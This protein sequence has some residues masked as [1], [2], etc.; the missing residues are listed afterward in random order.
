ME[1]IRVREK[2]FQTFTKPSVALGNFDGVHLG[3]QEILKRTVDTAHRKGR[4]AVVYTFDPH[5][6]LVLNQ[7]PEIPQITTAEEKADL[8]GSLGID[9]LVLAEFTK[10]FARQTPEDFVENTLVEELAIR[11]LFVGENYRF[12][13]GRSGTP[14]QLRRMG[15][16]RGFSVHVV[17]SVKVRGEVVSS[18]LIRKLLLSGR[19]SEANEML[20]RPFFVQGNVI[21][22]HSRGK[23][24]GY[25]TA[26][27]KPDRKL[28]PPDGVYAVFCQFQNRVYQAVM[29]IGKNPTFHDRKT[30]FEAHLLDFSDELYGSTIKLFFIERLRPE[31]TFGSVDELKSQIARDVEKARSLL[32]HHSD[33]VKLL[34]R[35]S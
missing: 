24:L 3:H 4:E 13:S 28:R 19:I 8:L 35:Q 6:R 17:P 5:P 23:G 33:N 10:E 18:T 32:N 12:G 9:V 14:A 34:V 22:G 1:I 21:H 27:I 26:N 29:N 30:S 2:I 25:P 15:Q 31:R 16:E 20:G 11:N 7:A